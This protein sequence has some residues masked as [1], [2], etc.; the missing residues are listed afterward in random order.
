MLVIGTGTLF[1]TSSR[2]STLHKPNYLHCGCGSS[3]PHRMNNR[4]P[5]RHTQ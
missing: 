3:L 1:L 5:F 2:L 4:E